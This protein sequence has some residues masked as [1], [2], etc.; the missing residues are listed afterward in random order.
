MDKK[1]FGWVKPIIESDH[2]ILGGSLSAVPKDILQ[3]DGNWENFLPSFEAQFTPQFDTYGCQTFGTY[4]AIETLMKRLFGSEYNYAE[5]YTY[6]IAHVRSPGGDPHVIAETIRKNGLVNQDILPMTST[7][8][9]F[10]KP[11]P[12][13]STLLKLGNQWLTDKNFLHEWVFT[14]TPSKSAR[15]AL[16]K[17]ALRYSPVAVSVTAWYEENGVFID[18][19]QPNS[20]WVLLYKMDDDGTMYIFDSYDVIVNGVATQ[21]KKVLSPEHHIEFA[22]RYHI[23]KKNSEDQINWIMQIIRQIVIWIGFMQKEE[24]ALPKS[25]PVIVPEAPKPTQVEQDVPKYDW[26]TK[27]TVRR[28][29]RIICDEEGL[30]VL[31][32]DLCCDIAQCESG[33]KIDAKLVNSS[34]SI[35]RGLFQWNNKYHPEITDEI[36]FDPEKNT[37]LG[38]S[39]VK[40]KKAHTYWSASESCWNKSHKYD[41]II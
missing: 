34:T 31:Q 36:A 28:S 3:A 38:C 41:S 1:N 4:N 40:N 18:E 19:G 25:P 23:G 12:M 2:Y 27:T 6:N 8:E 21:I 9:E 5:R 22:K 20:H 33:L 39:A 16:L 26:S 32:K 24:E 37:R 15:I 29:I 13:T 7:Y 35:D 17:E 30:T 10:I 14:N 11:D